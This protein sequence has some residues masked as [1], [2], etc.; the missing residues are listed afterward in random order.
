MN[1]EEDKIMTDYER[2]VQQMMNNVALEEKHENIY[3]QCAVDEAIAN[4]TGQN[5]S[6]T[7]VRNIHRRIQ[8]DVER[9]FYK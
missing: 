6:D 1:Y 8:V 7:A 9:D 2:W 4:I 3:K 5:V